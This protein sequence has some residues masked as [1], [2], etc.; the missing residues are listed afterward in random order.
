MA[1]CTR[2]ALLELIE[3][4]GMIVAAGHLPEPV[5]GRVVRL[6]GTRWWQAL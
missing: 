5:F 4:E 6:E 2:K 3:A 1:N